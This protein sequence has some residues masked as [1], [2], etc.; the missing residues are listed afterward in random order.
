MSKKFTQKEVLDRFKKVHGDEYDYSL[1]DYKGQG[2]KVIIVCR[3]HGDFPQVPVSHWLGAG[4]PDCG[5]IQRKE[6]RQ[7]GINKFIER[8]KVIHG[9]LYGYEKVEY[10]NTGIEVIIICP[11]HGEFR[12]KPDK[13]LMGRGCQIC[14]GSSRK[15]TEHFI[16]DSKL[17]HGNEYDYSHVKYVNSTTIIKI[18]CKKD[19]HGIFEQRPLNHL[20]GQGCPVGTSVM[21][22]L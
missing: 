18:I 7:L 3:V 17:I 4:C 16:E 8:S 10:V 19:G 12:Q 13:H 6:K 1:V 9:N 21:V 20:T 5:L 15:T 14:G 22:Q 11:K 2:K